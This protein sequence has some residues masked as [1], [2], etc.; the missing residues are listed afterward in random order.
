MVM[1]LAEDQNLRFSYQTAYRFPTTQNQW[2]N[3]TIGGGT[4]LM[5]GLRELRTFNGFNTNPVFTP[6]SVQ[7]FGAS[8]LA[9]APNPKLLKEQYFGEFKPESLSYF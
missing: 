1:K 5:G 6:A 7:A 8:V 3:L 2:I 9:G 4:R